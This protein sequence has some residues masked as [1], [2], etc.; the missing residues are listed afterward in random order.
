MKFILIVITI[1]LLIVKSGF[2]QDLVIYKHYGVSNK[3]IKTII[4]QNVQSARH[5]DFSSYTDSSTFKHVINLDNNEYE[6][7]KSKALN[8]DLKDTCCIDGGVGVFKVFL[9]THGKV[10]IA[11]LPSCKIAAAYFHQVSLLLLK[12]KHSNPDIT[13]AFMN[14]SELLMQYI[15]KQ[16]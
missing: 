9:I 4:V 5:F 3:M 14:M 15:S 13:E 11:Y 16:K 2:S 10:Q 6:E 1:L 12:E 7:F 8:N